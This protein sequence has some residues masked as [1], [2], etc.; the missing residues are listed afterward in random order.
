MKA[1]ED[2]FYEDKFNL[3]MKLLLRS[4]NNK[5]Y[6]EVNNEGQNLFH[7]L[8]HIKGVNKINQLQQFMDTL[9]SKQIPLDTKDIYGNT[10]LHYAAKNL[11]K[12]LIIFILGKYEEKNLL[13][14]SENN[15]NHT[16]FYLAIE[17][18]NINTITK[19]IFDLLFSKKNINQS[20]LVDE[21]LIEKNNKKENNN[22]Y[23]CSLLLLL[24][25]L[26]LQKPN[27]NFD[28]F[29]QKLIQNGA[30]I[31]ENQL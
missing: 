3:A 25:R 30:S 7:I 10:P 8:G 6:Q 4:P 17:G 26:M 16:P 13:L 31:M 29:Y 20:N 28:Y 11:L 12:E 2:S 22:N 19:D 1:I 9:Y 27:V 14:N 21:T 15:E 5:T 24:I 23:K 18:N